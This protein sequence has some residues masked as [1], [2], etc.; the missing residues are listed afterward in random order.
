MTKKE[1]MKDFEDAVLEDVRDRQDCKDGWNSLMDSYIEDG[2]LKESARKWI[3][4]Y[5]RRFH[6]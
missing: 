2:M 1:F 6:E 3:N 4:P 5:L